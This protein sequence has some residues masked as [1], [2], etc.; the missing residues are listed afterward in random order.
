MLRHAA[1]A[2][3]MF[4]AVTAVAAPVSLP[5]ATQGWVAADK[6]LVI[7]DLTVVNDARAKKAGAWSFA[8]LMQGALPGADKLGKATY[9]WLDQVGALK[10]LNG[11]KL[12]ER[13]PGPML[14][15]W[16]GGEDL[17]MAEAPMRLLA[18]VFRPDVNEARFVF[19]ATDKANGKKDFTVIF[20][21]QIPEDM[22]LTAIAALST[23]P[24]GVTF[25]KALQAIT[26]KIVEP[27]AVTT[28]LMRVRTNEQ[29]FGQGW[30]LREFHQ[31][32]TKSR[33][34]QTPVAQTPDISL[35][36]GQGLAAWLKDNGA[37]VMA[38]SYQVPK[39]LLGASAF[40]I[41]DEFAWMKS[42]PGVDESVRHTF[43]K[44]TCNGCHGGETGTR[45]VHIAPRPANEKA[46]LS[47]FLKND[48]KVRK[49][50][51]EKAVCQ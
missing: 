25:N 9:A 7:N 20:E 19:G 27:R 35:D 18:V 26:D 48:L 10:T 28:H 17:V 36:G 41:D 31:D 24:F 45:F 13:T 42:V 16:P 50:L 22:G 32:E 12:D 29:Y 30:D 3:L 34:V 15:N 38:G 8:H 6:S 1:A 37:A 33:L 49:A 39:A 46:A 4:F 21:Y 47:T 5:C 2:I 51:L 14:D 40:L 11:Y 43:A 44:G 23:M